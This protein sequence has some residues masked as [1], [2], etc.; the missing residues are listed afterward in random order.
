MGSQQAAAVEWNV[1]C[2]P[3]SVRAC[4]CGRGGYVCANSSL[5]RSKLL[6]LQGFTPRPANVVYGYKCSEF[7][8]FMK[9]QSTMQR[10][11][12]ICK[13]ES[14]R[15]LC[16]LTGWDKHPNSSQDCKKSVDKSK[17]CWNSCCFIQQYYLLVFKTTPEMTSLYLLLVETTL[18]YDYDR[19][20]TAEQSMGARQREGK[21]LSYRPARLQRQVESIPG[22]LKVQKYH[23]WFLWFLSTENTYCWHHNNKA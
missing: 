10:I 1:R 14:L 4:V 6:Q 8:R 22:L 12:M 17:R 7:L 19:K 5:V 11:C 18:S 13:E 20:P 9:D 15:D 3:R 21:G 23:L 2:A 16:I